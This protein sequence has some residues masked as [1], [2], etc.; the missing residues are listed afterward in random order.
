MQSDPKQ[1]ADL[2]AVNELIERDLLFFSFDQIKTQIYVF[3]ADTLR[4][5]FANK[6]ALSALQVDI[7]AIKKMRL[8]DVAR[9]VAPERLLRFAQGV[10]RA[11]RT[12]R[13][14]RIRFRPETNEVA[15]VVVHVVAGDKPSIIFF[16]TPS[17]DVNAIKARAALAEE[18]L[19]L[20]VE[21]L[22]DGF[23]YYDCN[24]R[25]VICNEAYR[26]IYKESA[27]AMIK[28]TRFEDILRY[29]LERNQ[30]SL[31]FNS[32][33]AWLAKRLSDHKTCNPE[34]EQRLA[35][36][37]WLK[38]LERETSDGGRVGLR[39]DITKQKEHEIEVRRLTRSDEL[40]GLLNRRGLTHKLELLCAGLL[41]NERLGL[42]LLDLDRF[43]AVNDVYGHEA[44]NFLLKECAERLNRFHTQPDA[45]AR[46]GSDEFAVAI[47]GR[48]EDEHLLDL[49]SD[50]IEQLNRPIHYKQQVLQ[51]GAS[52]GVSYITS[53]TANRI[54]ERITASDIALN[55][56]KREG[57]NFAVLFTP[58]MREDVVKNIEIAKDIRRG[59]DANEFV[60]FF[61]PQ[62]DT[63]RDRVVGFEAL[64]RWRHPTQGMVPAFK[65]LEV[66]QRVGLT[67][68]LDDLVMDQSCAAVR[69]IIDW[70]L[71][72]A[73]V[74][75]NLSIAQIS[76]PRIIRRLQECLDRHG[77]EP[78]N[79]RVELLESTLLDDRATV[80]VSN[81]HRL[82]RAGFEVELDDFGT[83]HAAIA[84][85][86]KFEVARIKVDR[87][88]V[89]HIDKDPEL[90]VIT[91]ALID[92]A[93]NLGIDA[94]AEGVETR[95]EQAKLWEM[96]CYV[97]QGY[98][99]AK[100]MPLE[101]VREWLLEHG[102]ISEAS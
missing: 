69:Q 64:I 91:S 79:I 52:V 71:E 54:D 17:Q 5:V 62:L 98:L 7:R 70:G 39:V 10:L 86:R 36:G 19:S 23:A 67:E 3:D 45:I 74:S 81:V 26:Q 50:L 51:V 82:I 102:H 96:G 99:H 94:L 31:G 30:Y 84:T 46:I 60:P 18:Q 41:K 9:G 38:I 63:A 21:A 55:E 65:F 77:V 28:G 1:I 14:G 8:Q 85:L 2:T 93:Q 29:G 66:A 6:A 16:V 80:I 25:L 47:H 20:A 75:I 68:A 44:G 37:R 61:Q 59:L 78:E 89:T 56:A 95:D 35:D 88:L 57:G 12:V 34:I 27:P 97:A 101:S 33:E 72:S 24:D 49:S 11:K 100:P 13:A 22:P 43:K 87:S 53:D 83:G 90:Q 4:A 42:F 40:T 73:C 58:K 92:L 48:F 15:D 32:A 76:D